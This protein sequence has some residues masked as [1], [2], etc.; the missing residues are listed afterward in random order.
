M[1]SNAVVCDPIWQK[2]ELIKILCM[3]LLSAS[4]KGIGSI[5]T[6]KKSRMFL[7][8]QGQSTP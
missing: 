4:L 6:K 2:I 3:S 7:Y 5:A 8:V 1:P